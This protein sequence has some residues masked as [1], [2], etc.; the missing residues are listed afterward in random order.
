MTLSGE[1]KRRGAPRN[2]R[3]SFMRRVDASGG[4]EACHRWTGPVDRDGYGHI[5]WCGPKKLVHRVAFFLEHGRW[6]EPCALHTCD[7]PSCVNPRHLV[8]GTQPENI[9]DM[10]AK[11]RRRNIG[12]APGELH[13]NARL[14]EQKV[15]DI[16]ASAALCRVTH[17]ELAAR[18]GVSRTNI[19]LLLN[20]KTWAHVSP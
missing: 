17:A 2:D 6:P 16:R 8:E 14:T 1:T 15:R 9:A 11:G 13:H 3:A 18:Y 20:R 5:R 4:S 10:D 19:T 7:N 12:A